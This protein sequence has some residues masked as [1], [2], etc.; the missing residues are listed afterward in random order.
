MRLFAEFYVRIVYFKTESICERFEMRFS[1][2][3]DDD[4]LFIYQYEKCLGK[5]DKN[6]KKKQAELDKGVVAVYML[7]DEQPKK[8]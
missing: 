2:C 7:I 1:T 6:D 4:Y 5:L 8:S 3:D